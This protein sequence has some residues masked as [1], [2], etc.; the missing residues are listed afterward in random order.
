MRFRSSVDREGGH[1]GTLIFSLLHACVMLINS[2]FTFHY[3][4][5]KRKSE[6]RVLDLTSNS[7]STYGI[8]TYFEEELTNKSDFVANYSKKYTFCTLNK[9]HYVLI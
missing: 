2:P 1:R 4:A 3:R 8:L 9:C 6:N 7:D 5:Q